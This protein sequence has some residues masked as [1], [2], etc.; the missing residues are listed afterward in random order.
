MGA[1]GALNGMVRRLD[2]TPPPSLALL[3]S[4][5]LLEVSVMPTPKKIFKKAVLR[6]A[7]EIQTVKTGRFR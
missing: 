1:I 7:L 5:K 3:K 4:P 2:T 6:S